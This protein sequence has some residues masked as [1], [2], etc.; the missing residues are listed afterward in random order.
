[1]KVHIDKTFPF[2]EIPEAHNE[3]EN[4]KAKGKVVI[5]L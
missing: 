3:L 1:M 4:G 5:T 2:K